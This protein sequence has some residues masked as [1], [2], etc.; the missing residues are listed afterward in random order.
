L[1][2]NTKDNKISFSDDSDLKVIEFSCQG[3]SHYKLG[4]Q[5]SSLVCNLADGAF[6][7]FGCADGHSSAENARLGA[8]Y[9][10]QAL[11]NIIVHFLDNDSANEEKIV[12]F[13]ISE[14]GKRQ[15]Y[16]EW[17]RL[18][19]SEEISI[20]REYGTT[21]NAYIV[22]KSYIVTFSV[23]DGAIALINKNDEVTVVTGIERGEVDTGKTYSVCHRNTSFLVTRVFLRKD[24]Q[25]AIALTDGITGTYD[26]K[27]EY[28]PL[29]LNCF[30]EGDFEGLKADMIDF[31]ENQ[32]SEEITDDYSMVLAYLLTTTDD[33]IELSDEYLPKAD[34][35]IYGLFPREVPGKGAVYTGINQILSGGEIIDTA[36]NIIK[37]IGVFLETGGRI[38]WPVDSLIRYSVTEGLLFDASELFIEEDK[39]EENAESNTR[40]LELYGMNELKEHF[41]EYFLS[42]VIYKLVFRENLSGESVVENY[43]KKVYSDN[44]ELENFWDCDKWLLEL[45]KLKENEFYD[46][47][48]EQ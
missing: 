9:A 8:E 20:L 41:T 43:L 7:I 12:K 22:T 11:Q 26:L 34:S 33:S 47:E 38:N 37:K 21:I 31:L 10:L 40:V 23:G 18:V 15:Y 44:D 32:A 25:F 14:T 6:M 35:L 16:E 29:L 28:I 30:Y 1:N 24:F 13:L 3:L 45:Q 5:D 46:G 2:L 17:T 42:D 39:L 4:R 19:G 27:K 48:Q 36:I